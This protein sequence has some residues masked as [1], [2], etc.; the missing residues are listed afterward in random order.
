RLHV[1]YEKVSSDDRLLVV[2]PHPDDAEIAAFG[3]YADTDATVV[4]LTAGDWVSPSDTRASRASMAKMRVW[5]SITIPQFG[6]VASER[7][8]NLCFT[9]GR[10]ADMRND[11]QRDFRSKGESDL[12][13]ASLR[14]INRSS[15]VGEASACNW[16]SLVRDLSYIL[17]ETKPTIIVAPHPSLDP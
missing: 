17:S 5:D 11:P 4:T 6:N 7:A 13:F 15:L 9:D 2:A 16:S 10:L 8:P 12:D 1:C 14:R 3:L